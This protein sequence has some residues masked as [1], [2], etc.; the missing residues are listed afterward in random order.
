MIKTLG[1][2]FTAGPKDPQEYKFGEAIDKL[3]QIDRNEYVQMVDPEILGQVTKNSEAITSEVIE[4]MQHKG[5]LQPVDDKKASFS[6]LLGQFDAENQGKLYAQTRAQDDTFLQ[7]VDQQTQN[8]FAQVDEN[9]IK[10]AGG[11]SLDGSNL[12]QLKNGWV[13]NDSIMS[14]EE[15]DN[16]VAEY[17]PR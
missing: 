1:H 10:N 11:I 15:V 16:M 14:N 7:F 2:E 17:G 12:V 5:K 8:E 13:S 4:D 6:D 9:A 3:N